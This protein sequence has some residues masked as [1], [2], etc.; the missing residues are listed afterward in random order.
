MSKSYKYCAKESNFLEVDYGLYTV[1][2]RLQFY[3]NLFSNKK[4]ESIWIFEVDKFGSQQIKL[5]CM[6]SLLEMHQIVH[7]AVFSS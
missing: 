3:S 5:E 4:I 1:N 2:A 7:D 6:L